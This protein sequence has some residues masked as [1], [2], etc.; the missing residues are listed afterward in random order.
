MLSYLFCSIF[1]YFNYMFGS[2]LFHV[3]ATSQFKSALTDGNKI[4]VSVRISKFGRISFT[5]AF[6]GR[7]RP[8][9][10]DLPPPGIL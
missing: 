7:E 3:E 1:G 2:S 4:V 5:I 9:V 6:E 8:P 10:V